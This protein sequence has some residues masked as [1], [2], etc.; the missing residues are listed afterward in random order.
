MYSSKLAIFIQANFVAKIF[1]LTVCTFAY[2]Q[3]KMQV[4]GVLFSLV[5]A[6]Y[7]CFACY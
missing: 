7:N 6:T 4:S 3:C 5:L 2:L 1:D